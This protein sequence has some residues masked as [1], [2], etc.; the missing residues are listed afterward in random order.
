MVQI[1]VKIRKLTLLG[2]AEL[3]LYH[4]ATGALLVNLDKQA[5]GKRIQTYHKR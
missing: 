2:E 1:E 5:R 3:L 4:E